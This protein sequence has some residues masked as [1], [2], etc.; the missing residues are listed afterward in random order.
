MLLLFMASCAY[1][2][3]TVMNVILAQIGTLQN[4]ING[5]PCRNWYPAQTDIPHKL[6][7]CTM[8]S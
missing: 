4:G 5:Y 7:C 8:V 3:Q 6:V 2:A 1:P